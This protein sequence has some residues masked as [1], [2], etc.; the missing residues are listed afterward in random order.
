M[1]KWRCSSGEDEETGISSNRYE[2]C[3]IP[4]LLVVPGAFSVLTSSLWSIH[5][6]SFKPPRVFSTLIC[7]QQV[8]SASLLPRNQSLPIK[9]PEAHCSP[10]SSTLSLWSLGN[11]LTHQPIGPHPP[12]SSGAWLSCDLLFQPF[13]FLPLPLLLLI[14][15]HPETSQTFFNIR[16]Q[17]VPLNSFHLQ[18]LW[19]RGHLY[20]FINH[21]PNVCSGGGGTY[22]RITWRG[23]LF[24]N[25]D[26]GGSGRNV[27]ILNFSRCPVM[28][29]AGLNTSQDLFWIFHS[30]LPVRVTGTPKPHF[31]S[32]FL[33]WFLF[34][35][36]PILKTIFLD[37][38]CSLC[39]LVPS[40]FSSS[41]PSTPGLFLLFLSSLI[42]HPLTPTQGTCLCFL[43][44][45]DPS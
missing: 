36:I 17:R 8:T 27:G 26:L 31:L 19:T 40:P 32:L 45:A 20:F 23:W 30:N 41:P 4:Q 38:F 1:L 33:L 43:F 9:S 16:P 29:G 10:V 15:L 25:A 44:S 39:C 24:R 3:F 11:T 35:P 37:S 12:P 28:P 14:H 7:S 2:V 22:G 42:F 34:I 6:G 21:L 5:R 13:Q 18:S